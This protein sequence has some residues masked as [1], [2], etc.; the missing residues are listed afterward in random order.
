MNP[1]LG[2]FL[3]GCGGEIEFGV[4]VYV[5]RQLSQDVSEIA[6]FINFSCQIAYMVHYRVEVFLINGEC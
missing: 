3:G 5:I 1:L 6:G 4:L 2:V